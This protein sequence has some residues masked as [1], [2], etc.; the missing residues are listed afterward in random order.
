MIAYVTTTVDLSGVKVETAEGQ[1][2]L[3]EHLDKVHQENSELRAELG[4]LRAS[5]KSFSDLMDAYLRDML[6]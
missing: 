1:V 3:L 5:V 4:T 6:S 2:S